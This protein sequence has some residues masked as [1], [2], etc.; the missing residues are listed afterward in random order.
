MD[1]QVKE[2]IEKIKN[3]GVVSAENESKRII[4][5]A[6]ERAAQMLREARAEADTYKLRAESEIKKSE[7]AGREALKQASRDILI[8]LERQIIGQF[9]AVISDTVDRALTTDLTERL[10]LELVKVWSDKGEEGLRIALSSADAKELGNVL[11]AELSERFKKGVEVVPLPRI[12]K[13]FRIGGSDGAL[14]DFTREGVTEIL[15]EA[16][17]P[18]LAETLNEALALGK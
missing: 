18:E 17:T 5:E 9:Q 15:A 16:L 12:S 4:A 10:I 6:E 14:Y 7:I 1:I 13:G 8:G 3:E 2:L 11:Q